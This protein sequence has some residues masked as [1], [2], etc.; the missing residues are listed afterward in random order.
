MSKRTNIFSDIYYSNHWQDKDSRSGTGS[1]IDQTMEIRKQLPLFLEKYHVKTML[2]I[3]CGDFYWMKE[4][5]NTLSNIITE[6]TGG[7]IVPEIIEKN[8]QL[9]KSQKFTFKTLDLTS[10]D[11]PKADLVF[12]RDCLVH[13]SYED[14]YRALKNIKK[15]KSTF[16]LTTSFTEANRTNKDIK[17]GWWRPLN[18]SNSP[19]NFGNPVDSILEKCTENNGIY[20]DKHLVLYLIKDINLNSIFFNIALEKVNNIKNRIWKKLF[21]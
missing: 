17:T 1:N 10:S 16:F 11:L 13:L 20:Y 14:I 6:Y 9:Y 7:D 4:L 5:K 19:F 18:L 12:S 3:P 15:S 8:N 2:D 21:S